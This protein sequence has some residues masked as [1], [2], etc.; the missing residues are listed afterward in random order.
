MNSDSL[1]VAVGKAFIRL[2]TLGVVWSICFVLYKISDY[3]NPGLVGLVIF[4]LSIYAFSEIF[5]VI[6]DEIIRRKQQTTRN[7]NHHLSQRDHN[8]PQHKLHKDKKDMSSV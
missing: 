2:L 1:N 4:F 6:L 5:S 7:S 3:N 8:L